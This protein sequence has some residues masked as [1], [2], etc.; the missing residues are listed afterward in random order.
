MAGWITELAIEILD[1]DSDSS[2]I[3]AARAH[4]AK[5][6]PQHDLGFEPS[7]IDRGEAT[8]VLGF[9]ERSHGFRVLLREH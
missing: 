9:V 7:L 8:E 1:R 4:D 2:P 6:A 5:P 3:L